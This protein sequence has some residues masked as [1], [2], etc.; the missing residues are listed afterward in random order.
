MAEFSSPRKI[1]LLGRGGMSDVYEA[2]D[3][4]GRRVALKVFRTEKDS[5]FLEGRFRV[6]A[7][8]LQTLYHP[9]VVR[10]HDSGIDEEGRAWYA[11]D[12][13]LSR[14]GEPMT[15]EDARRKGGVGDET[16]RRWF[17]EAR[18]ALDY[19]HKCGVVH[20]DVKLENM[21]VDGEGSVRL[22]DFGVSRIVDRNLK[23]D[24]GVST[25]FV[26]GE[27]TGTRPV[28]GTYF[29]LPP[30]IRAGAHANAATDGYALGVA[31]FRLLTGLWY[32]PG[33]NALDLLA[34]FPEYWRRELPKLLRCGEASQGGRDV[35]RRIR[36]RRL[37]I[38]AFAAAIAVVVACVVST[39]GRRVLTPPSRDADTQ[40]VREPRRSTPFAIQASFTT[41]L[42]KSLALGNGVEMDFCACPAGTFMM[43]NLDK[44]TCHKVTITRP[45][46]IAAAPVTARQLRLEFPDVARDEL[47]AAME[48]AFTN[49]TVVCKMQGGIV[50]EYIQRLNMK[51][52]K[53]LPPG[54]AFR[55]PTEAELEYA[56]REGGERMPDDKDVYRDTAETKRLM[57]GAGLECRDD[58]RL[59]P[60]AG[61]ASRSQANG[62]GLAILW[63]DTEQAVLDTVD[64]K[65]GTKTARDSIFYAAEET[66]PLRTGALHLS[67]QFQFQRWL[68]M[69]EPSGFIRICIGPQP[70]LLN[71]QPPTPHS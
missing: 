63:T 59:I 25:T 34:P 61:G 44:T 32:E 33:T 41:P 35:P 31:F 24:L 19:L 47:A 23:T 38:C 51:Y 16:L 67:R 64:G 53:A 40:R 18:D 54:Y 29:Y 3:A 12:L 9:R 13:V 15:L 4:S 49:M 68:L 46:W 5:R 14:D 17:G 56:I 10:V 22:A 45:F 55:L 62:F 60:M 1:R 37:W 52:G 7:K 36:R 39:V 69:K 11:M 20:R 28:M 26:T 71:S 57:K 66:D 2:E 42:V 50:G 65:R 27:T 21:L 58:L 43:S 8:L 30:E 70:N 48:A 6:E